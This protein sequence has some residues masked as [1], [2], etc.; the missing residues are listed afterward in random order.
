MAQ[1]VFHIIPAAQELL[2]LL[3]VSSSGE[4]HEQ[5]QNC[6][7]C[8]ATDLLTADQSPKYLMHH[9]ERLKYRAPKKKMVQLAPKR[10]VFVYV[11]QSFQLFIRMA[12]DGT[13]QMHALFHSFLQNE[14]MSSLHAT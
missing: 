4:G 6:S 13:R 11:C 12:T 7:V 2:P 1:T 3:A 8:R 5:K 9:K 14:Q 10:T